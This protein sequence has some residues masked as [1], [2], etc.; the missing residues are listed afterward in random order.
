MPSHEGSSDSELLDG[1]D[2]EGSE[3]EEDGGS[4]DED[5]DEFTGG[6]SS[7]EDE[8]ETDDEGRGLFVTDVSITSRG[9]DGV[10]LAM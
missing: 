4:D 7:D 9:R 2:D 6:G 3:D 10:Q 5:D 1:C 8:L